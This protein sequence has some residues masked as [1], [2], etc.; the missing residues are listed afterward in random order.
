MDDADRAVLK[1]HT[2][3]F[4]GELQVDDL[5]IALASK[6]VFDFK[7]LKEMKALGTR[8]DQVRSLLQMLTTREGDT[9]TKFSEALMETE[10]GHLAE[11][12]S[13]ADES[14][15][16]DSNGDQ[17]SSNGQ[18]QS[19]D[20]DEKTDIGAPTI[21]TFLAT[22]VTPVRTYQDYILQPG[23]EVLVTSQEGSQWTIVHGT[24]AVKV[25]SAAL[26]VKYEIHDFKVK[27]PRTSPLVRTLA[28][29]VVKPHRASGPYQLSLAGGEEVRVIEQLPTGQWTVVCG[30]QVGR[31][32]SACL[33]VTDEGEELSLRE[34]MYT[35]GNPAVTALNIQGRALHSLPE[36]LFTLTEL[37][38]LYISDNLLTSLPED[39]TR[40]TEVVRLDLNRNKLRT[41]PEVLLKMAQLRDLNLGEN[42][43]TSLPSDIGKLIKLRKLWLRRLS[44]TTLPIAVCFL[45]NLRTLNLHGNILTS[46]DDA[47]VNLGD[48]TTLDASSN[49]FSRFPKQIC[50][51]TTLQRLYMGQL[52]GNKCKVIPD[53]IG[54]LTQLTVLAVDNNVLT[55][56]PATIGQ[57]ENLET[58]HAHRNKLTAI[59]E[60]ISNLTKL[61]SLWLYGN[62][63]RK[64]PKTMDRLV[65]L[66]DFRVEGNPMQY[67]PMSVCQK[68]F[69]AIKKFITE[70]RELNE[71]AG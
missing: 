1:K 57:L 60:E 13:T 21:R 14:N 63:I 17:E 18:Q 28:A 46:L 7:A 50:A 61:Q 33:K 34:Q 10:Q 64:L 12:L 56:L 55:S 31:V 29:Q 68:G 44:L 36:E 22:A 37:Q 59:P 4:V 11:L 35:G 40:L 67:P 16:D 69:G 3:R 52:H 39:L 30:D 65:S 32:D 42:D 66:Q 15:G 2:Q 19:Q 71:M 6:G 5:F 8:E 26:R 9:L 43:F 48:L 53:A 54:N 58:L 49:Q 62:A 47:I 38:H 41:F 51:L 45:R 23:D 24:H 25:D 27:P 20:E 70:D